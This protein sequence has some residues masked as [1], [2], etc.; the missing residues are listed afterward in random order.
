M[1]VKIAD[2]RKPIPRMMVL[3]SRASDKLLP[4]KEREKTS[5]AMKG[6]ITKRIPKK[7]KRIE[8]LIILRISLSVGLYLNNHTS[9]TS[10][11]DSVLLKHMTVRWSRVQITSGPPLLLHRQ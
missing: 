4:V 8:P 5:A 11:K 6:R 2:S 9:P 1:S 10:L 3:E 7:M